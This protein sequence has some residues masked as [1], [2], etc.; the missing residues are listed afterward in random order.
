MSIS[1]VPPKIITFEFNKILVH[2][3]NQKK[4]KYIQ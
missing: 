3:K 4:P 1:Q 2:N